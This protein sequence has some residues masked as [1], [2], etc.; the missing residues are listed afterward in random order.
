MSS[1][2]KGLFTFLVDD[3]DTGKRL[4]I[5]IASYFPELSRNMASRL[6]RQGAITVNSNIKKPS[7]KVSAG[8]SISGEIPKNNTTPFSP[9]PLPLDIIFEDHL[10]LA[11]NKKPGTVV[12]PSPGHLSGTIANA[13]IYHRP[14]LSTIGDIPTRPGI[15]HRLDKDTS[16][17]MI[18]AKT[19]LSHNYLL[20]QF[21]D[22]LIEKRY[23]GLVFGAPESDTGRI[24]LNIGR[25]PK[26]RKKMAISENSDARYAET[27]WKILEKFDK[28]SF[29]EF[30]IKTGRTHQIRVH[31]LAM[32][33][34]IVGD[35]VYNFKN[36]YKNFEIAPELKK[37]LKKVSRQMLHGWRLSFIHPDTGETLLLE[38]PLPEDMSDLLDFI[39]T[40]E[41]D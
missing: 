11:I 26:N 24:V 2:S 15:V 12:H 39:H 7:F 34:P 36:P 19:E 6:L 17:I 1:H 18:V 30:D 20:S 41:L 40:I 10:F 22:R 35:T 4:D 14:E 28:I 25:H 13:L 21:K 3:E 29:V 33:H 9:E 32:D 31:C 37:T 38:A 27:H 16:G 23:L 8:D 5:V